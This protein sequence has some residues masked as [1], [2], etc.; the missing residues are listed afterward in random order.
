[1][2]GC[3]QINAKAVLE[4]A[5]PT[6]KCRLVEAMNAEWQV[7]PETASVTPDLPVNPARPDKPELVDPNKVP[8]RRLGSDEGRAA[9]LHA[10]SH[11][12]L[13]AIDLA[14]D[15]IA[16]FAADPDLTVASRNDFVTDWISVAADEAR[17][18]QMLAKRLDE[19]GFAYGD[20]PAHNGLW[21]AAV[22]TRHDIAARLAIAPLVLEARGLDVTPAIIKKLTNVND[23][24]SVAILETIYR[25]E[26]NH[27]AIGIRWFNVI[28]R[29]R[30]EDPEHYFK[31]LVSSHFKGSLKPPF[32]YDART[33]AGMPTAF[34]Q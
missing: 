12:E 6:D 20:F 18:F 34:Y 24:Q 10:I 32:N 21:E 4:S 22:E 16:R 31:H 8:R 5:L 25:E 17:H 28:A 19:L 27:V 1:M 11:I 13:N 29:H 15:M 23:F 3:V 30:S 14:C 9:M 33:K 26:V 7:S 2:S